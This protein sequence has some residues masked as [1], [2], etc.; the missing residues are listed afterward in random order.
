VNG[1]Q[2][3]PLFPE[4]DTTSDAV[5]TN[6]VNF[7]S[8]QRKKIVSNFLHKFLKIFGQKN[9]WVKKFLPL[10][11]SE[12]NN[13]LKSDETLNRV[14][15][16]TKSR[17]LDLGR[18]PIADSRLP[19]PPSTHPTPSS[20]PSGPEPPPPP[21]CASLSVRNRLRFTEIS[22][23]TSVQLSTLFLPLR[24]SGFRGGGLSVAAGC[25]HASR[26]Q[27]HGP[28]PAM[29]PIGRRHTIR[30]HRSFSAA[31]VF[32]SRAISWLASESLLSLFCSC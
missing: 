25:S 20:Q 5:T 2:T 18:W 10:E 11:L 17:D 9:S 32:L 27:I 16:C 15:L 13:K 31:G 7:L 19:F 26:L 6:Y 29:A 30:P 14:N 24:A 12:K 28:T 22:Q 1:P 23:A 21:T 3:R 4:T 8:I